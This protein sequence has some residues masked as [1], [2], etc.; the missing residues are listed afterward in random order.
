M[1]TKARRLLVSFTAAAMAF[2]MYRCP[3]CHW[4]AQENSV[5]NLHVL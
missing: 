4:E 3:V 2:M 5:K 1:K